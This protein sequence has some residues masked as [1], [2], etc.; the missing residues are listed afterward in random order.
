MEQQQFTADITDYIA[1]LKRRKMLLAFVAL[2]IAV[3]TTALAVGLPDQYLSKSMISFENAPVSGALPTDKPTH[4][5]AYYDQYVS[6][7][8]DAVLDA[9]SLKA[10][11]TQPGAPKRLEDE[12]TEDYLARIA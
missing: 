4:E 3:L 11:I 10:R 1:A 6:S 5:K 8:T 2:P 7:L 12:E 9:R